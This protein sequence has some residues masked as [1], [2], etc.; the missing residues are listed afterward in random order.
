MASAAGLLTNTGTENLGHT[1]QRGFQPRAERSGAESPEESTARPAAEGVSAATREAGGGFT[2]EEPSPEGEERREKGGV[3]SG[4]AVDS[5]GLSQSPKQPT[6]ELLS[7]RASAPE[8]AASPDTWVSSPP[9]GDR[10]LS[11][12]PC[13]L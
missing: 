2:A 13:S 9:L 3:G 4:L 5:G 10:L 6:L 8:C 1:Q 11:Q 12:S 7:P